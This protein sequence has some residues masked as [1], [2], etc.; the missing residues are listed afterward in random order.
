MRRVEMWQGRQGWT[1]SWLDL[2]MARSGEA[3]LAGHALKRGARQDKGRHVQGRLG[4]DCDASRFV[5]AW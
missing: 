2:V 4:R 1:W 5:L 3:R